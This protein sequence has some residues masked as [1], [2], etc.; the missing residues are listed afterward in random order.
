[1]TH[2]SFGDVPESEVAQP[3]FLAVPPKPLNVIELELGERLDLSLNDPGI[4]FIDAATGELENPDDYVAQ[5]G[6]QLTAREA[7]AI[8]D[9]MAEP[10]MERFRLNL[11]IARELGP[12]RRDGPTLEEFHAACAAEG[13]TPLI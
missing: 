5:F 8:R 11:I 2:D 4:P 9:I 12:T 10:L 13:V 3:I 6:R 1:M 7:M